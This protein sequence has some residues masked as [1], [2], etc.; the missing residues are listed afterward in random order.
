[1]SEITRYV[2]FSRW[3][4][5]DDP[6]AV[7]IARLCI[8]R[9]DLVMEVRNL[10]A[11]RAGAEDEF[12]AHARGIYSFRNFV[13]ILQEFS[14]TVNSLASDERFERLVGRQD[15]SV[16]QQFKQLKQSREKAAR[17]IKDVRND[18]CG[19]VKQDA[20]RAALQA[21]VENDPDSFGWL[22]ITPEVLKLKFV[23][24]LIAAMLLKD[25]S[26]EERE[27]ATSK[28]YAELQEFLPSIDIIQKC[29]LIYLRDK[30]FFD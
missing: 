30:G 10:R 5:H 26:K 22:E 21:M 9:E 8:I 13:R 3:F 6:L 29:L 1:M 17:V 12:D 7:K 4:P 28:K 11:S 16:R 24:E 2:K 18:I 25:V 20:V 23:H 14:S 27:T 19:H 15:K